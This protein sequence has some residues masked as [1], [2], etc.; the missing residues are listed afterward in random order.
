MGSEPVRVAGH[1]EDPF[2]LLD[3]QPEVDG[4]VP[5]AV[6]GG[7]FGWLG[8]DL[9]RRLERVSAPPPRPVPLPPFALA[10]YDHLLRCDDDGRWWFE[11]LWT[12]ERAGTLAAR[13]ADLAARVPRSRPFRTSRWRGTPSAAG[14]AAAV[15]AAV[16]RI[17]HGDLFQANLS[18]RLEGRLH[19]DAVDLFVAGAEELRPERG[20][21]CAGPWGALA[22]LSPELFLARHGRRVVSAPIKGTRPASGRAELLASGKDRAEHV[23]I[24]D[25]VRNDLGRVCQPGSVTVEALAADRHQAGVWHLVSEV[26]GRLPDGVGD[27]ELVRA[28]F[29]PGSVTGAP[30]VAALDV[31]A[32]LESTGR[33]AY[34]GSVGFA[35]PLAGLELSVAIRTFEVRGER[36][37]CG[38]GGGVV[39]ESDPAGEAAECAV[40]A[41]PLLAAVGAGLDEETRAPASAPRPRRRGPRSVPRPEPAAGVFETF[42]AGTPALDLHLDRLRDSVRALYGVE[43]RL[44]LDELAAAEGRVR[45]LAGPS[46]RVA[47]QGG[48]LPA[49]EPVRLRSFV[50]PGGLGAH[51]WRD[52]RLLDALAA[53]CPGEL[54]LLV[55]LDGF[56]LEAARASVFVVDPDGAVVTP[57]LDGRILP[58]VTRARV[59]AAGGGVRE[60]PL[61]L[62][63]LL[64]AREVFVTGA[65][66]GVEPATGCDGVAFAPGPVATEL[67]EALAATGTPAPA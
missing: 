58:G 52:R 20:A 18:R 48:P 65:L 22:S 37:W 50:V 41:G 16:E 66:R 63:R 11:A 6:G 5:G 38:V 17:A 40:K 15:A 32:E 35:S 27:A 59:L 57:P 14:H 36:V 29:P 62:S 39:A 10:F 28:A 67:A 2:A 1:D 60:E 53:T 24:V 61:P 45:L 33:E 8:Y 34:C 31:I 47:V 23:M 44:D 42:V 7:W 46:G 55:D 43:A 30:K 9:G 12:P 51:K 25:L 19:G 13:H 4:D 64:A 26:A 56:V 3:D 21:W 54:P 49:P